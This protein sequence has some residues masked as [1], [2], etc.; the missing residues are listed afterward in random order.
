MDG[1]N[2]YIY[3]YWAIYTILY[4]IAILL[5]YQRVNGWC[6]FGLN[7]WSVGMCWSVLVLW[8]VNVMMFT[9][10]YIYMPALGIHDW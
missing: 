3:T 6:F 1:W 7:G 10:V 8:A 5:N 9:L 2:I 4:H